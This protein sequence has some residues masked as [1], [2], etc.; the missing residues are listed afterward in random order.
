MLLCTTQQYFTGGL[1]ANNDYFNDQ[2]M[3]Q[4]LDDNGMEAMDAAT[5][6]MQLQHQ[7]AIELTKLIVQH[8]AEK[9][10]KEAIFATFEEA[11]ERLNKNLN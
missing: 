6:I 3:E 2:N 7:T 8:S 5:Q 1:M 10:S 4:W 11:L 9:V